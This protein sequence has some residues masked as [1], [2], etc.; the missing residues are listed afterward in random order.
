MCCKRKYQLRSVLNVNAMFKSLQDSD[1][2]TEDFSVEGSSSGGKTGAQ[3]QLFVITVPRGSLSFGSQAFLTPHSGLEARPGGRS[4][5][6]SGPPEPQDVGQAT[7]LL[8]AFLSDLKSKN[9]MTHAS[10][11]WLRRCIYGILRKV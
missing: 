5:F 7:A 10:D 8:H 11:T 2:T 4:D 6:Q 1:N 9:S 3:M